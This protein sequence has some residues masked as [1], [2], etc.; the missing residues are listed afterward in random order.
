MFSYNTLIGRELSVILN[1]QETEKVVTMFSF[2]VYKWI[3]LD[4]VLWPTFTIC[5]N[6]EVARKVF[7]VDHGGLNLM[8]SKNWHLF[9]LQL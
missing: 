8:L 5:T 7:W 1:T 2:F 6:H 3:L 9:A 4:T